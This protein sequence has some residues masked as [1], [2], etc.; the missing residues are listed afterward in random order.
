MRLIA[1]YPKPG[2]PNPLVTVR[3]FSL[4]DYARTGR[5]ATKE[6]SWSGQMPS[7]ERIITEV[8]WVGD[9]TLLVKE[10]DRAARNGNVVIIGEGQSEG[11]VV[12]ILGQGG[13]EGDEGWIDHV[14]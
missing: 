11:Q 7:D 9:E 1:R 10:T 14:G 5:A 8:Q 2:T 4:K 6:I 13:E 12:R 3:T